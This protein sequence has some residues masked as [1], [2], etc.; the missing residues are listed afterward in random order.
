MGIRPCDRNKVFQ[1][2]SRLRNKR[3]LSGLGLAIVKQIILGHGPEISVWTSIVDHNRHYLQP[4]GV[5]FLP[6]CT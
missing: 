3:E 4:K 2:F 1:L 5:S 6:F